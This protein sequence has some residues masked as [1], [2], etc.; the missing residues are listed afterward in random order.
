MAAALHVIGESKKEQGDLYQ[1]LVAT[2]KK[3]FETR[4]TKE[5][6]SNKFLESFKSCLTEDFPQGL[7]TKEAKDD[8][9]PQGEQPL[10]IGIIAPW[11]GENIPGGAENELK[12]V[13]LNLKKAG[14][15]VEFLTTTVKQ[16]VSDWSV[17]YYPEGTEYIWG[18]P[19]MRFPVRKRDTA[20]FDRI[21]A[22]LMMGEQVSYEEEEVFLREMV[23]SPALYE[24][25]REAR[26]KYDFF[27][28]APYLLGTTYRSVCEIYDQAVLIPCFHEEA[29]AHM[30]HFKEE[31]KK[32]AGMIFNAYPE[33]KL[34]RSLYDL[35]HVTTEVMGIG[36][37]TEITGDAKR[38]REKYNL[39]DPFLLY[40]GR[41]DAGKGVPELF[42][43]FSDFKK[44]VNDL[45]LNA[46][47]LLE[48]Q[49]LKL[50]LIGGGSVEIP[51]DIRED[52]LDL[53]FVDVQDK[54]D[55][56]AA[57]VALC[58]LSKHESFSFVIMESWLMKRPVIVHTD[59]DVTKDFVERFDGGYAI[60]TS[61][62][63]QK[64]VA[65]LLAH[66]DAASTMG[67]NGC[68]HV[69][70]NFSWDVIVEKY[71]KFFKRLKEEK[72]PVQV[73]IK[74]ILANFDETIA[75]EKKRM[76]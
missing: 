71:K 17:N 68:R 40:A 30:E 63:F 42:K 37:D 67:E 50:V 11:F 45:G 15:E 26:E 33:E 24:Y 66:P 18:I 20:A 1:T 47:A 38:F 14:M 10:R 5:I 54:F 73:D 76:W 28:L 3:N 51:A 74:R 64:A 61:E 36:V 29:Y 46:S 9:E 2:G 4:F 44:H 39:Q 56:Y 41:K 12:T 55:A 6:L 21:N 19:V 49:K 22:R 35:S 8:K 59:C 48:A 25:L 75:D 13:G 23:N 72:R 62:E 32:V 7:E 43:D 65:S 16:F 60:T 70:E 34:A 31:Y 52:V 27:L 58:Q 57:A 69:H 53:G